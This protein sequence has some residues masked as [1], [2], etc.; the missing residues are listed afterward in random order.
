MVNQITE[1]VAGVNVFKVEGGC[2]CSK[3]SVRK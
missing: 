3:L 2:L 1:I